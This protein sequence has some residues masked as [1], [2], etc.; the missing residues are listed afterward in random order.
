MAVLQERLGNVHNGLESVF[1]ST[2]AIVQ[3][4]KRR[5]ANVEE[6]QDAARAL[7]SQV[8]FVARG[9]RESHESLQ[10]WRS[11]ERLTS[12]PVGALAT[13]ILDE[14]HRQDNA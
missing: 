7:R 14:K 8:F 9:V 11:G 10:R 4:P 3:L 12:Q 13:E 1:H 5:E 2:N 6:L